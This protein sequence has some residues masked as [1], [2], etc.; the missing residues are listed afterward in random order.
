MPLYI[1]HRVSTCYLL[2]LITEPTVSNRS[3]NFEHIGC[4]H[5]R[6]RR[7]DHSR[8]K[9][10]LIVSGPVS[11][12][13]E[14]NCMHIAMLQVGSVVIPIF[15]VAE[16][17]TQ[18]HWLAEGRTARRP[19]LNPTPF[20][21]GAHCAALQ[22]ARRQVQISRADW[23]NTVI[24]ICVISLSFSC[25]FCSEHLQGPAEKGSKS[26]SWSALSSTFPC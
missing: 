5:S 24:L 7:Y 21:S 14:W 4:S 15:D 20:G 16:M 19:D 26:S 8:S 23:L 11:A 6:A 12:H 9:L 17:R 2:A 1:W 25:Y 22:S 13:A 10:T 18:I 3:D